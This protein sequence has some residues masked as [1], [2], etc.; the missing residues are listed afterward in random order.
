MVRKLDKSDVSGLNSLPPKDWNFDY[1]AFLEMYLTKDY[2]HPFVLVLDEKVIG[3]GN[4]FIRGS[5]GWLAHIIVD[6]KYRGRGLGSEMTTF[7]VNFLKELKCETMLL[8]A[9]ELGEPVYRKV[10]FRKL[11]DYYRFDTTESEEFKLSP[12]IQRLSEENIQEVCEL[13]AIINGENRA[14]LIS[15]YVEGGYGCFDT[16]G[17]LTG[18]YLPNF[19]RG[20]VLAKNRECGLKLLEQKHAQKGARTF[21]P[22]ENQAA[23]SFLRSLGLKEGTKSCKMILGKQNTWHPELIYSYGSGFCG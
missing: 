18:F 20:L 7:L 11:S 23:I 13:D 19:G 12:E 21:L 2:F 4:V 10:G 15:T 6:E 16:D 14:H 17:E 8:I 1:E 22:Q 9:T 3:T 5:V